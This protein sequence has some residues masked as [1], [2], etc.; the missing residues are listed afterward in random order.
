MEES[1]LSESDKHA[2]SLTQQ[3]NNLQKE[4]SETRTALATTAAKGESKIDEAEEYEQM[5]QMISSDGIIVSFDFSSSM[6]SSCISP[7]MVSVCR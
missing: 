5:L 6:I 2:E 7:Y 4:L 3:V 1:K